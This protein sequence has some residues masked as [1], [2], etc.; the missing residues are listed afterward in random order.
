MQ[1]ILAHKVFTT[2]FFILFF[3]G[4]FI[5]LL[6]RPEPVDPVELEFFR[7]LETTRVN[8]MTREKDDAYWRDV[9][10]AAQPIRACLADESFDQIQRMVC[11]NTEFRRITTERGARF[12]LDI[13]SPL[14]QREP[15]LLRFSHDFAHTIGIYALEHVEKTAKME[16]SE[17][18]REFTGTQLQ[19]INAIGQ[20]LVECDGW[21]SFGCYHGVIE[22]GLAQLPPDQRTTVIRQACLENE[23]ILQHRAYVNQCLHWFGHGIAIFTDHSLEESL[24][25]CEE[26]NPDSFGSD[27]VQLCLSGVFHAGGVPGESDVDYLDN[28]SRVYNPDDVYYPCLDVEEKFKS[29]CFSQIPARSDT[30]D[31]REVYK[32]C[33][34][35][36]ESDP[37]K[38]LQYV[39]V[40]YNGT[41]N[42]ALV[43]SEFDAKSLVET[44]HEVA[45]KE[46]WRYCYEGAVRYS[47]LLDPL[48]N[49]PVPFEICSLAEPEN[50]ATCYQGL[51]AAN[52]ENY[53]DYELV[54]DYCTKIDDMEYYEDC[55]RLDIPD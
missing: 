40:C 19:L 50:K 16:A 48:L 18:H 22:V 45:S 4:I 27:D 35:I 43:Y 14:A 8:P 46:Y 47:I 54:K 36:P 1:F 26:L 28:I 21:G 9:V 53:F 17:G 25:I 49:N 2:V 33:E 37:K 44:C 11:I 23:L 42:N 15:F 7:N 13:I 41:S 30:E 6:L 5:S 12:S 38:K 34:N 39:H 31:L 3:V 32:N 20:A 29:Q 10:R 24:Q 52:H 51:G 55:I